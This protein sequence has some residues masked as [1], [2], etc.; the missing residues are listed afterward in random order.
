MPCLAAQT[1]TNKGTGI[2]GPELHRAFYLSMPMLFIGRLPTTTTQRGSAKCFQ[3]L[4]N[5]KSP[6][7]PRKVIIINGPS[8]LESFAKR[9]LF[10]EPH[11]FWKHHRFRVFTG[12][13]C[14]S[15]CIDIFQ[16][17]GFQISMSNWASSPAKEKEIADEFHVLP[18]L[19]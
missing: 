4:C 8:I 3:S 16:G 15:I 10:Y 9:G 6:L 13:V 17:A 7:P 19:T 2:Q 14:L 11:L 12:K 5:R 1:F 18:I